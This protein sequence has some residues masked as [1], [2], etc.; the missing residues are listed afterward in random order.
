MQKKIICAEVDC[1]SES[2][3][4]ALLNV[5]VPVFETALL[6]VGGDH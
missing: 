2:I 3:S 4:I 1:V 5:K 6:D